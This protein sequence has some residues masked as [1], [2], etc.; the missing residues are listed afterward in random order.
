MKR[1]RDLFCEESTSP[2][3]YRVAFAR[4]GLSVDRKCRVFR[5]WYKVIF[6][7]THGVRENGEGFCCDPPQDNSAFRNRES[8]PRKR[9]HCCRR[10]IIRAIGS[11]G[12]AVAK[13]AG[14]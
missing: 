8:Y 11:T 1:K 14:R 5:T 4:N 9:D 7:R 2:P 12:S 6:L 13:D 10:H 3:K